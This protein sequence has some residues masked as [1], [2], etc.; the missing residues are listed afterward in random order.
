MATIWLRNEF[1]KDTAGE[2]NGFDEER[3]L[4]KAKNNDFLPEVMKNDFKK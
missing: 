4:V 3:H 1:M 2:K